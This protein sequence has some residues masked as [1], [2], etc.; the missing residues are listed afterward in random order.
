MLS[1]AA[2]A[3]RIAAA[4]DAAPPN[5]RDAG[6]A[7]YE[8][9]RAEARSMARYAP[10][11]VG[12]VRCAAILA[13]LS[14]RTQWSVNLRWARAIVRAA[15]AGEPCPAV[16]I[17]R[18]RAKAWRIANG[19]DPARELN[20]PKTRAFWRNLAGDASAVTVD[21]WAARAAGVDAERELSRV[22]AY[23][24]VAASYRAVASYRAESPSDLQAIVWLQSRG[25]KPTDPKGY[26]AS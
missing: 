18:N 22:G 25:A 21:V 13:A 9:G 17:K 4:Y 14:P 10:A 15:A 11:G 8:S 5:V 1:P 23:D 7:W 24:A 3:E 2:M 19:A 26:R 16:S 6:R 12:A 20:G